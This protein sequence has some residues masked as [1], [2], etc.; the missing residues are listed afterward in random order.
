M[1]TKLPIIGVFLTTIQLLEAAEQ[2]EK[3]ADDEI[4]QIN[5]ITMDSITKCDNATPV[6]D[7]ADFDIELSDVVTSP[8][9]YWEHHL[10][11]TAKDVTAR[12]LNNEPKNQT[13][14]KELRDKFCVTDNESTDQAESLDVESKDVK[15]LTQCHK[16][17]RP[18]N[19]NNE[20]AYLPYLEDA[21]GPLQFDQD[22]RMLYYGK[23]LSE[24]GQ[25]NNTP[26]AIDDKKVFFY[27]KNLYPNRSHA[28]DFGHFP[29]LT[30]MASSKG[31]KITAQDSKTENNGCL[32]IPVYD[33][34]GRK[35]YF[36]SK[37]PDSFF[38]VD[39]EP[40]YAEI[41]EKSKISLEIF[42]KVKNF[43]IKAQLE[44]ITSETTYNEIWSLLHR[45]RIRIQADDTHETGFILV[46]YSN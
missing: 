37:I 22:N 9:Y 45:H 30:M 43:F 14:R 35:M 20:Q 34:S 11:T 46:Q 28:S 2:R 38:Y 17:I 44:N 5:E 15:I 29:D 26:D 6:I 27:A 18:S 32:P 23:S 33:L 16:P 1:K 31:S 7:L 4:E 24:L 19:L 25:G 8:E 21:H 39:R 10:D 40:T 42:E 41:E 3:C 12:H 13:N 36:K